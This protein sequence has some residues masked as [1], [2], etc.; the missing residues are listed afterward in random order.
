MDLFM[1]ATKIRLLTYKDKYL[2]AEDDE[3][4]VS[5]NRDGS[6]EN[7]VWIVECE[8]K[9]NIVR[10][11]SRFGKY[12]SASN[13]PIGHGH[14]AKKVLQILPEKRTDISVEWE[15]IRDGFQVR[16][17]TLMGDFLRPNGGLPPY[18]NVITHDIP[19]RPTTKY[20]LLWF[21]EVVEPR[22]V[23]VFKFQFRRSKSDDFS[24]R[25]SSLNTRP[26]YWD[27]VRNRFLI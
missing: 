20:K 19:H 1:G 4:S 21:I 11:K 26:F 15:P 10:F 27:K 14:T 6:S 2:T 22:I 24:S 8:E 16:L 25:S 13:V 18:R 5:Q 12:L 7:S 3:E 17:K 9:R 23:N